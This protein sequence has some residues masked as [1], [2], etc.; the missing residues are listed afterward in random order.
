MVSKSWA[1]RLGVSVVF[2]ILCTGVALAQLDTAWVRYYDG[3]DN[4]NDYASGIDVDSV[5]MVYVT[6]ST[7]RLSSG[8]DDYVTIKYDAD[9]DTV[10]T[11]LYTGP[12]FTEANAGAVRVDDAQNVYLRGRL[13]T[14]GTASDCLTLKY[15]MGGN[16][17]WQERYD[18]GV[19]GDDWPHDIA[20]DELGNVYITGTSESSAGGHTDC[21]TVKYTPDGDT[22]WAR[23]YDGG[24]GQTEYGKF[25]RPAPTGGVYVTGHAGTPTGPAILTIKYDSG[26]DTLWARTYK[27]P[28]DGD[29]AA[30]MDVDIAGYVYI[31]GTTFGIAGEEYIT[32][33]YNSDGDTVWVRQY[34]GTSSGSDN[35]SDIAVDISGNVCV[36]GQSA[37]SGTSND[38]ATIKY[39][40]Y[41]DTVWVRR[42]DGPAHSADGGM[43]LG[44][45]ASG[46]VYVTG[47][48]HDG[49][50]LN[51]LTVKYNAQG[52]IVGEWLLAG[53]AYSP[54]LHVDE[55][56]GV[57]VAG[58]IDRGGSGYDIFTMK[59]NACDC[60]HQGDIDGD[61]AIDLIDLMALIDLTFAN[62]SDTLDPDCPT[63]RGDCNADGVVDC[64]DIASLTDCLFVSLRPLP[65]PC[66]CAGGFPCT[67]PY[68]MASDDSVVVSSRNVANG[69][70]GAT[71]P[72]RIVNTQ[73]LQS[74]VVPLVIRSVTPGA[75]VTSLALSFEER[76]RSTAL[77][78]FRRLNQYAEAEGC[79]FSTV[80]YNDSLAH[81]VST[82][83]RGLLFFGTMV[84]HDPL[85]VGADATGSLML[86]VSVTTNQGTFEIDT[87]CTD[88]ANHLMFVY[89][90]ATIG[91]H[92][93]FAKGIIT[94]EEACSCPYQGDFDEDGFLTATDLARMIDVL[95][96]GGQNVQDPSCPT[97]RG[98]FDCDGFPTATDLS[99]LI[100]HLFAGGDGPCDPCNP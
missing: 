24:T 82:S 76:L 69:A 58:T 45:D 5:G 60:P 66:A 68:A 12:S 71:I 39:N 90:G 77:N 70:A 54:D 61:D 59:F 10:W 6:G 92:P 52:E 8:D 50:T 35:A 26:G 7:R 100:D 9:G 42:Y 51:C 37:G 38:F 34:A 94:I 31:A 73:P 15:D 78:T 89:E 96:A 27:G 44:V 22:A 23:R 97:P 85:T 83:P 46:S 18:Y 19:A 28:G 32:I 2:V 29:G 30:A 75:F 49:S 98:D 62:V 57:S 91:Y 88:P 36:T 95:F 17:I 84:N 16:V 87:A 56:G 41:G 11:R 63:T 99:R 53:P 79:G 67:D 64:T 33:K 1:S 47:Q 72:I 21:L 3:P 43:A 80:T 65:D 48:S 93:S 25:V 13:D 81:P 86:T 4:L 74:L 14:S 55:K 20:I 40:L